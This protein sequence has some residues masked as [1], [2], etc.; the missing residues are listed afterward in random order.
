MPLGKPYQYEGK[1]CS[2]P[3]ERFVSFITLHIM[4]LIFKGA[5]KA[6]IVRMRKLKMRGIIWFLKRRM[7]I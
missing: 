1:R 3:L 7:M 4:K 5:R 6:K 2:S